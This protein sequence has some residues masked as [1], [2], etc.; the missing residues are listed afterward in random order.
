MGKS[1]RSRG[2]MYTQQ[3]VYSPYKDVDSLYLAIKTKLNPKRFAVILHDKD[4]ELGRPVE[5][6][7]HAMM[8]FPNARYASSVAKILGDKP[9]TIEIWDKK[10]MTGFAYLTHRTEGSKNKYQYDYSEVKANFDYGAA[11]DKY[12]ASGEENEVKVKPEDLLDGLYDGTYS[13]NEV[14]SALKGSQYGKYR[15][16]IEDIS[17]KRLQQEAEAFCEERN[18]SGGRVRVIWLYGETETGK[19]SFAKAIAEKKGVPYYETGSARDMF[20]RYKGEHTI[21]LDEFR[22]GAIPYRD[23]LRLTDPYGTSVMVP[24]RYQD[25]YL[26]CDLVIITSPYSPLEYYYREFSA[27]PDARNI[28]KFDQ[29]ERRIAL[30]LYVDESTIRLAK[31]FALAKDYLVSDSNVKKNPYSKKNRKTENENPEELFKEYFGDSI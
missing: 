5:H 20:Q 30:T 18:L 11:V 23:L 8:E 24:S 3:V 29:L 21:I 9:Q 6:H 19:T 12:L 7:F 25:K 28:D 16:Q 1:K 13:K 27:L 15:K 10:I 2:M 26:A 17:A 14:E 31:Y 4:K 22:D